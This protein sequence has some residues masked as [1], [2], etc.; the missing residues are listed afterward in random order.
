[1]TTL[2]PPATRHLP[3]EYVWFPERRH[4]SE[5]IARRFGKELKGRLLDVGCDRAYLR[6]LLSKERQDYMGIDIGG[7]PDIVVNL[8]QMDRLPFEDN[9]F[10]A[11]VCADVLEHVDNLHFVFEELL[12]VTRGCAV[13]SLPNC[14]A[15]ARQPIGR[16]RGS[17]CHY[18][19]PAERPLD[20]HKWF[21]SLTE[22]MAFYEAQQKKGLFREM[23]LHATEKPR[24]A[25]L[26]AL[27]RI[28][29]PDELCYLNRY[30]HTLWAVLKK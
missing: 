3:V 7:T 11:V 20:R 8:E 1:M 26:R 21:F 5:Y 12:R 13:I 29:Y 9:S 16:G 23:E 22:A 28:R 18:G 6:E 15:A 25:A 2:A 24:P 19:L 4:R 17:F 30:A 27:R 10:D 14:W